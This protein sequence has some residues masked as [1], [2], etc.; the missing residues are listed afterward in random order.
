[1]K[2]KKVF[3]VFVLAIALVAAG[4]V[5]A[6]TMYDQAVVVQVMRANATLLG[7]VRTALNR[8]DF[9]AAAEGFWKFA[10]GQNRIM[11]FT[12]PKGSKAEWDNVLDQFVSLALRGVGTAGEKDAVKGLQILADLQKLN[13]AGHAMFR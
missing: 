12:P 3:V 9:F 6:Q 2:G 5:A 1:M 8:A 7:Q 13:Q 11:K 4:T 10:E